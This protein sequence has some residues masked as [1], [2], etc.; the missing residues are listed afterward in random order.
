M[1]HPRFL[2]DNK[3]IETTDFPNLLSGN[4]SDGQTFHRVTF[5][6]PNTVENIL[7]VKE[8]I[9]NKKGNSLELNQGD[10]RWALRKAIL[11][12]AKDKIIDGVQCIK[13]EMDQCLLIIT[14]NPA[15]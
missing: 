15:E 4:N 10:R 3:I 13:I 2:I 11:T 14:D 8:L 12:S 9:A 1:N 7:F 5:Y 6:L